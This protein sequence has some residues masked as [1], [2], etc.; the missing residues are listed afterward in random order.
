MVRRHVKSHLSLR[1][2]ATNAVTYAILTL[3]QV[4]LCKAHGGKLVWARSET[5]FDDMP[6]SDTAID[7]ILRATNITRIEPQT[8]TISFLPI[9][10]QDKILY[11]ATTSLDVSAKLGC[12]LGLGSPFSWVDRGVNISVQEFKRHRFESSPVESQ[13]TFDGVMR[14]LSYKRE[15][16]YQ[17]IYPSRRIQ[18]PSRRVGPSARKSL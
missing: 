16:G 3:R 2:S 9:E 13:L 1:D 8:S 11:H 12:E 18:G 4:T 7:M 14:G 5:L 10:I 17:A 15:R 6:T